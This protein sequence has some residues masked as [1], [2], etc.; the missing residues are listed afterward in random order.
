LQHGIISERVRR[1]R[2]PLN[3]RSQ[4]IHR[5][6]SASLCIVASAEPL[7]RRSIGASPR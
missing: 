4:G 7:K 5:L 6:Q 2:L 1:P 3:R